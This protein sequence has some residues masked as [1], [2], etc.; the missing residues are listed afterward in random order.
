MDIVFFGWFL[1]VFIS[2]LCVINGVFSGRIDKF[3]EFCEYLVLGI[4]VLGDL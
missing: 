3:I 4:N 1:C 2:Y